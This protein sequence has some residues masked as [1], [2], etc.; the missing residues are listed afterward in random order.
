MMRDFSECDVV[1]LSTYPPRECGIATFTKDLVTSIN[2]R[3]PKNTKTGIIAMNSNGV[4]IYN[5][6]PE[7]IYQI[8]DTDMNDYIEAARQINESPRIKLVNIQHEFGIF[9]GTWGDYL[10]AFLEIVNKPVI[11]TFHSILP[12]PNSKLRKV[13]RAICEKVDEV[14]VMTNK[15]IEILRNIY[16]VNTPIHLIPHGIPK[17]SFTDQSAEKSRLGYEGKTILSSFG[18]ISSGKGYEHVI[19]ALPNI[20][21]KYPELIYLIIGE[22]HPIVR[23]EE[24]EKYRN[25]L[26]DRIRELKLEKHVKFYNKYLTLDE[27]VQYLKLTDV[28]ISSGTNL[29]QITSGTLPYAMGCGRAVVSTS[30]LHAQD[31]VSEERGILVGSG[32]PKSYE[33]AILDILENPDL[34]K[35]MEKNSYY[36]TRP[37]TWPNVAMHYC[38]VFSR[39]LDLGD[40]EIESLP[41]IDTSHLIR[42]TDDFGIIQFAV[43]TNPDKDSGYT[44]DDNAR[45]ILVC[46]KHYEKFREFKQLDLIRTYLNYIKYVQK[47]DGKL[48]NFVSRDKHVN[49]HQWSEDAHGRAIW[50]L[51]YLISSPYIPEDFKRDA[52]KIISRAIAASGEIKSPRSLSFIIHGL[53][54]YNKIANSAKIR[55]YI[56][57]LTDYLIS[58]YKSASNPSWKWFEPYMTY[59]NSKLPEALLYAYLATGKRE[60]FDVGLE[61]L[62]FLLSKTF[63]DDLFIP[64]GQRGWYLKD[65]QKT[66]YDQ[67]PIE[68]SY[69]IQ[70]L[71]LAYKISRDEKYR[72][73]ALQTFQWFIGKNTL[74][75]VVYDPTTGGCYDGIGENAINLNQGAESTISYLLARLFLMD[76]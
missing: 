6:P 17:V 5:Y 32:N 8:R 76:L 56:F 20:V 35:Q 74:N 66:E 21:R 71:I 2:Q 63:K 3:L 42:L 49:G 26:V 19:E 59:A 65:G 44:L 47:K 22:T 30:F 61:S 13:V 15:G 23:K 62:D 64:V 14:V 41:E 57:K 38:D 52:E 36:Y 29:N 50:A 45:A 58:L 54:F 72:K 9:R 33:K 53:Y 73:Y 25:F 16:H 39:H 70:T 75:Q 12:N 60:Y 27:I 55:R 11:I 28:Y 37:M 69:T 40:K 24:G 1:F 31:L 34:R 68:A 67:Q 46:T 7:V 10:L 18:M 48:Y 51:G 43:Q 4:N